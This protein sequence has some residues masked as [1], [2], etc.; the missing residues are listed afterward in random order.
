MGLNYMFILEPKPIP[1]LDS[2]SLINF[3]EISSQFIK[4]LSNLK[5]RNISLTPSHF[6]MTTPNKIQLGSDEMLNSFVNLGVR[7]TSIQGVL[8][9]IAQ[10]ADFVKNTMNRLKNLDQLASQFRIP[11]LILG[12]ADLRK[13][14]DLWIETLEIVVKCQNLMENELLIENIC[15]PTCQIEFDPF[16][17]DY[18]KLNVCYDISNHMSCVI[19]SK[20]NL[21]FKSEI[22]YMHLSN[23]NHTSPKC[24]SDFD[25]LN[26]YLQNLPT[27]IESIW[28][29]S[30]IGHDNE[31]SEMEFENLSNLIISYNHTFLAEYK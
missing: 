10:D 31:I 11:Y 5:V 13:N 16:N 4:K 25:K 3:F 26:G 29:I 2:L 18:C 24:F 30:D 9:G 20:Q 12:S 21:I 19:H 17:F 8:Y 6:G 23:R 14:S 27:G 7:P 22:K 15:I 1:L 28:E